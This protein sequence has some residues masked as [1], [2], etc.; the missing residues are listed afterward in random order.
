MGNRQQRGPGRPKKAPTLDELASGKRA[1]KSLRSILIARYDVIATLRRNGVPWNDL[2][3]SISYE[4]GR[5]WTTSN[6]KE[7]WRRVCQRPPTS[8]DPLIQDLTQFEKDNIGREGSPPK[9]FGAGLGNDGLIE[10]D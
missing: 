1:P 10:I 5:E 9:R 2:A 4:Y 6:V 3:E 7:T 8:D